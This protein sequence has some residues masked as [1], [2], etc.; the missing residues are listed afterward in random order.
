MLADRGLQCVAVPTVIP[1]RNTQ[2]PRQFN[3]A[4]LCA[5]ILR[6]DK[7][8]GIT[9]CRNICCNIVENF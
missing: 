1:G 2:T 3:Y 8:P 6:P 5:L 9:V 4:L 7:K